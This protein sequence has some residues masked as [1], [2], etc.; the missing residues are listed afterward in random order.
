MASKLIA[1]VLQI[2]NK[3]ALKNLGY[4]NLSLSF[5]L[6]Q[7]FSLFL[8]YPNGISLPIALSEIQLATQTYVTNTKQNKYSILEQSK[9]N[10]PHRVYRVQVQKVEQ[11]DSVVV[12]EVS[13][14]AFRRMNLVLGERFLNVKD[15]RDKFARG[16]MLIMADIRQYSFEEGE[17]NSGLILPTDYMCLEIE[18]KESFLDHFISTSISKAFADVSFYCSFFGM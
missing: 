10:A 4:N 3:I 18:E 5:V 13:D 1:L 2:Y 17:K 11:R 6:S 15:A 8:R 12:F 14:L 16:R 9:D 7:L